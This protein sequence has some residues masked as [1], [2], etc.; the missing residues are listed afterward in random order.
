MANGGKA[1]RMNSPST[2]YRATETRAG[3]VP[4]LLTRLDWVAAHWSKADKNLANFKRK[5]S[6]QLTE[7]CAFTPY[8]FAVNLQPS[9]EGVPAVICAPYWF[10]LKVEPVA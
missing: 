3:W 9:N 8:V 2:Y 7:Q 10:A 4:S 1:E 5:P 6:E